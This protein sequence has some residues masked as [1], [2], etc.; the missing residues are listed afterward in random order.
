MI[1]SDGGY[2]APQDDSKLSCTKVYSFKFSS[3][4]ADIRANEIIDFDPTKPLFIC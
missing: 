1:N 4:E 3:I 2:I